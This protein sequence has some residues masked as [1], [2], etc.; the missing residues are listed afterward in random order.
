MDLQLNGRSYRTSFDS[1][2]LA[3]L[4]EELDRHPRTVAIELN[5]E[6]VPR[7][8]FAEQP[9]RPGDRIEIVQFVQGG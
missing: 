4:L 7:A 9:V 2:T 6:I 5:G 1:G 3:T 8:N